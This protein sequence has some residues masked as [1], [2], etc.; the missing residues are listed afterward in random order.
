[1]LHENLDG[2]HGGASRGLRKSIQSQLNGD[3]SEDLPSIGSRRRTYL[4]A[5]S[6]GNYFLVNDE[7]T[8][9][10]AGPTCTFT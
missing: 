4:D 3:L 5:I 9:Y 1:M 2:L 7:N 6:G 8:S 10:L